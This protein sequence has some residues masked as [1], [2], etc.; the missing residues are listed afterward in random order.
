MNSIVCAH[1]MLN[2]EEL[3]AQISPSARFIKVYPSTPEMHMG[4]RWEQIVWF[5]YT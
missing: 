2:L 1:R 5:L 3:A 4:Q